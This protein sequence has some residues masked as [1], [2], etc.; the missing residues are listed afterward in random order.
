MHCTAKIPLPVQRIPPLVRRI[1]PPAQIT[2]LAPTI[3]S[4][5]PRITP[6]QPPQRVLFPMWRAPLPVQTVSPTAQSIP[7]RLPCGCHSN[8]TTRSTLPAS[9]QYYVHVP[10][11]SY[12]REWTG[13]QYAETMSRPA[14][15]ART[16]RTHTKDEEKS[17][18]SIIKAVVVDS[19]I[20]VGL[21]GG[22]KAVFGR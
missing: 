8:S 21:R 1:T 6:P 9:T 10:P 16:S 17:P 7:P 22:F 2:S 19:A 18:F 3:P 13:C 12:S 11:P 4:P 14:E 5:A 15:G 20:L